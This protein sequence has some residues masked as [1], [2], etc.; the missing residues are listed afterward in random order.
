M[1]KDFSVFLKLKDS[2]KDQA[3]R[4]VWEDILKEDSWRSK[5]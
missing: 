1:R 4:W 2:Y 5:C 3:S